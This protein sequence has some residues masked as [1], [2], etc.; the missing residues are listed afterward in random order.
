GFVA[1]ASTI[2]LAAAPA[3]LSVTGV[4][5]GSVNIS[6]NANTNAAG[7]VFA[8]EISSDTFGTLAASTR[9]TSNAATFGSLQADTTYFMRVK[10]VG[11]GGTDS[12]YSATVTTGTVPVP[13]GGAIP[14]LSGNAGTQVTF[15][16]TDNGNKAGTLYEAQIL[17]PQNSFTVLDSSQTR[18][19][20]ATFT[21]LTGNKSYSFRARV[22]SSNGASIFGNTVSTITIPVTPGYGGAPITKLSEDFFSVTW[23][24]VNEQNTTQ[25]EAQISTYSN[26]ATLVNQ[27]V[28]TNPSNNF[29]FLSANTTY[30]VRAR[31]IGQDGTR[32]AFSATLSTATLS[33]DP[34]KLAIA[35][36]GSS[37]LTF[38]YSG[39][40]TST[41]TYQVDDNADFSSTVQA[42]A[43]LGSS[44]VFAGGLSANT[45]YYVRVRSLNHDG[46]G[47]N[48][49]DVS[50]AT[51]AQTVGNPAISA[52]H[53]TSATLTWTAA[54]S[55]GYLVQASTQSDFGSVYQS[56]ATSDGSLT[57]LA[58]TGLVTDTT[59]YFRIGS[60]NWDGKFNF[61]SA[62]STKTLR[63]EAVPTGL[64]A[65][66]QGISS[67]AWSWNSLN[68]ATSYRLYF[69]TDTNP[70]R[71]FAETAATGHTQ[72]G[73]ST[74]T[75]Y[76]VRLSAVFGGTFE[77]SLTAA[78]TAYTLAEA[79]AS[80]NVVS[81]TSDTVSLSWSAEG[82]PSYTRYE[83]S[84]STDNFQTH[85]V[86]AA[87]FASG[88]TV[89]TTTIKGL[90]PVT[91]YSVRIRAENQ[92]DVTTDFS[93]PVSTRTNSAPPSDIADL[94]AAAGVAQGEI[95]IAWT[96]PGK[97]GSYGDLSS[98]RYRI[99]ASTDPNH[100]FA[101]AVYLLDIATSTVLGARESY[102]LTGLSPAVTYYIAVF[103]IDEE[104]RSS[105]ASNIAKAYAQDIPPSSV[106]SPNAA[107]GIQTVTLSWTASPE[108]DVVRYRIYR[109]SVTPADNFALLAET[110]STLFTDMGLT[111]KT[112][113]FY[114]VS[115]VDDLPLE[116]EGGLSPWATA[117]VVGLDARFP[118]APA[119]VQITTIGTTTVKLTWTRIASHLDGTPFLDPSTPTIKEIS[120]YQIYV[121]TDFRGPWT[122]LA[123][124]APSA[125]DFT[126]G[127]ALGSYFY[128]VAS[129][130][131]DLNESR[132]VVLGAQF[133]VVSEDKDSFMRLPPDLGAILTAGGNAYGKDL[134]IEADLRAKDISGNVL[135]SIEFK[136]MPKDSDVPILNFAFPKP[137]EIQLNYDS[138]KVAAAARAAA[139]KGSSVPSAAVVRP[140]FSDSDVGVYWH[141]G[142]EYV[143]VYGVVDAAKKTVKIQTK[144]PGI[145]QVRV[146][147][148]EQNAVHF[149]VSNVSHR[150][151]TPNGDHRNDVLIITF[152]NPQDSEVSGKI[153]DLTGAFVADMVKT[154][155]FHIQW[156]GKAGGSPVKSGVYI[157]QL[158]GEGRRFTGTIVVAR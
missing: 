55:E 98:G 109:D 20:S 120:A 26:F 138:G 15:L 134:Q 149:D 143:K 157:Y 113:Y 153:Y 24:S 5:T 108:T 63:T 51:L 115:A 93:T 114:R 136:V 6:W 117:Y 39:D 86:T 13:P 155:Q 124:L 16:W 67:I 74:N 147:L 29:S 119:G 150:V 60:L 77:N 92:A 105:G 37:S 154:G 94:T 21:S 78:V 66:T 81:V 36:V 83:V 69:T 131:D 126:H 130:D 144:T 101:S 10:A 122:L 46:T 28:T 3:A 62:G 128:Q 104:P 42:G 103:T 118:A 18:N 116:L 127:A 72:A 54:P 30:Y 27:W 137:V 156:D 56:S 22:L 89:A 140:Q 9:T 43:V 112:T 40:G 82:N 102:T 106:Q 52:V 65:T 110:T 121:S 95:N 25:F 123:S 49:L 88:L 71:H 139:K 73:L 84:L 31:A 133:Y 14:A 7:T 35:S 141:N 33:S 8:A 75:A 148:R 70:G 146:V 91:T 129:I 111:Y 23:T 1:G 12:A 125:T 38:T 44:S 61:I 64:T 2:T 17:D 58:V 4:S 142:T 85:F 158:K 32:S 100:V 47:N 68:G 79:P 11:F 45:T 57:G 53:F 107:V 87:S 48:W 76:G 135:Q 59:Y 152:D 34:K 50:S 90:R 132:S 151:I 19:L 99:D 80:L 41:H 96:A 145:Y 97:D